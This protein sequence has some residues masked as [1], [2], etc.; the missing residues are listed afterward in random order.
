MEAIARESELP[1]LFARTA[2]AMAE[3]ERAGAGFQR[4]LARTAGKA[5]EVME[6]EIAALRRR[7]EALARAAEVATR[8]E[9]KGARVRQREDLAHAIEAEGAA[10][11]QA[12]REQGERDVRQVQD[13]TAKMLAGLAEQAQAP[14]KVFAEIRQA[15]AEAAKEQAAY[16]QELG[17]TEGDVRAALETQLGALREIA[18]AR[19][20][21]LTLEGN[22]AVLRAALSG[23]YELA[24]VLSEKTV[25]AQE[26]LT[27]QTGHQVRLLTDA[28]LNRMQEQ[29]LTQLGREL[30]L[31]QASVELIQA[32]IQAEAATGMIAGPEARQRALDA[33]GRALGIQLERI[34]RL[35]GEIGRRETEGGGPEAVRQLKDLRH[36]LELTTG[37]AERMRLELWVRQQEELQKTNWVAGMKAGLRDVEDE[38]TQFGTRMRGAVAAAA[39][40]AAGIMTDTL[41]ATIERDFTRLDQA[42]GQFAR[43]FLRIAVEEANRALVGQAAGGVRA[44]LAGTP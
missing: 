7:T 3:A 42:A 26:L 22:L 12:I 10:R 23:Q 20:E 38:F 16:R 29:R 15:T 27:T 37:A 18:E 13:A 33:E 11:T 32:R 30:E 6:A 43:S 5:V 36:Q 17:Q 1:K 41:F 25:R 40:G 39:R 9:A 34:R 44:L 21:E 31:R 28:T 35:R 14:L 2:G 24:H 4:G 19:R 8:E